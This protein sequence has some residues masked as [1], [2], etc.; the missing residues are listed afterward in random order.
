MTTTERRQLESLLA[1][2]RKNGE[3]EPKKIGELRKLV[4][5]K[6]SERGREI[7]KL[8][9]MAARRAGGQSVAAIY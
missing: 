4:L 7:A 8:E 3:L 5:K 6:T 9:L 1:L 2:Y